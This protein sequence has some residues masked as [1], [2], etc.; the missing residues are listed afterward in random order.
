MAG[1]DGAQAQPAAALEPDDIASA[2]KAHAAELRRFLRR[3]LQCQETAADLTQE[4]YLKLMAAPSA[5][6]VQDRRAFIFQVARNLAVDHVRSRNRC[7]ELEA[8]LRGLYEVTGQMQ[9]RMDEVVIARDQLEKM[10]QG[11]QELPV[12]TRSVFELSR[13][14]GLPRGRVAE[15]LQVSE[16]TVA[17]HLAFALVFMRERLGR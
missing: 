7:A 4:T 8:G 15:Q 13:L 11:L 6:P 12:L 10:R 16:S 1:L 9:P 17:K 5:E 3:R 2:F 14:H